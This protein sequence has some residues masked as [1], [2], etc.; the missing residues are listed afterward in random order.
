MGVIWSDFEALT[1]SLAAAFWTLC[2]LSKRYCGTPESKAFQQSSLES[3]KAEMSAFVALTVRYWLIELIRR[4]SVYDVV[5]IFVT[6]WCINK[7][8]SRVAPRFLT[9]SENSTSV[10][11]KT[12]R[13]AREKGT[14]EGRG[15][16]TDQTGPVY[17]QSTEDGWFRY[18]S[19]P[20]LWRG[21]VTD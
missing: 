4:S 21:R 3:I 18:F 13:M 1:V 10:S 14:N 8:Q 19:V 11:P 16:K 2:S 17:S 9:K 6:C 20:R 7:P 12:Q 5:Q 15:I